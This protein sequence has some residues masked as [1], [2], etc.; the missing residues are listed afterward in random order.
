MYL[1]KTQLSIF[2]VLSLGL[3]LP[4]AT[5]NVPGDFAAIQ[6]AID[7]AGTVAG[8]EIVVAAGT[9]VISSPIDFMGKAITLR[10]ASG[11][12]ADT[13]L[14]GQNS[15]YHIVQCVSGEGADTVLSGFTL[16]GGC[17]DELIP[18]SSCGGGMYNDAA[19]PTVTCCIFSQN[20]AWEGGGMYND[21]ASPTVTCCIFS[22]NSAWE[23]GGM[24]NNRCSPTLTDCTFSGNSTINSG[25]GG[26]MRNW[27]S[28]PTVTNCTFSGNLASTGGGMDNNSGSPTVT[29]CTFSGN[30]ASSGGGGGMN[31]STGSP[32]VTNCTFLGN[33]ASGSSGGGG[34]RNNFHS[35]PILNN[36]TFSQNAATAGGA[37][38]S[39]NFCTPTVANSIFWGNSPDQ[40]SDDTTYSPYSKSIVYYSDVQG[41][42]PSLLNGVSIIDADPLFVDAD[43]PDNTPGTADDDLRLLGGSP[44]I[45]AGH[46]V[47]A[48]AFGTDLAGNRRIADIPAVADTG[49][50]FPAVVD[51]GA[52]E[53]QPAPDPC[54]TADPA[55]F[56]CSGIVDLL[57]FAYFAEAWL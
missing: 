19:S 57:D 46:S 11:N 20:S 7:D 55:D 45:D 27:G 48:S 42:L 53:Y 44:C 51:M 16:T 31:N 17:A 24:F 2:V 14:D 9:Y 12:P 18:G 37:M 13:I 22:Q 54:D 29:H 4:A 49:V 15:V 36:C 34:M 6:A 39:K 35:H 40:I 21:A 8:D 3:Y 33:S 1:S 56:D 52:Y 38:H 30:S 47:L 10:S 23:G 28:S 25:P 50:G 41:G 5:I 43:G 32:T 26:G